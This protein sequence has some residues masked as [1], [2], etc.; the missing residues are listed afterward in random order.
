MEILALGKHSLAFSSSLFDVVSDVVNS[1]NFLGYYN[2][3]TEN[4]NFIT[5]DIRVLKSPIIP[6]NTTNVCIHENVNIWTIPED[7]N[8]VHHVWGIVSMVLVFLPGIIG[9]S[10]FV[11]GLITNS[12]IKKT[13]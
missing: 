4:R 12:I 1:L 11:I 6:Q 7:E 5:D 2:N 8:G 13:V 10:L 3:S 9:G